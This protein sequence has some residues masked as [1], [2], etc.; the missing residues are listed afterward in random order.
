MA[1]MPNSAAI[2]NEA[3]VSLKT[4]T[5]NETRCGEQ[6]TSRPTTIAANSGRV[7]AAATKIAAT[8]AIPKKMLMICIRW[9]TSAGPERWFIIAAISKGIPGGR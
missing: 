5:A 8:V 6:A 2:M 1:D 4:Y 7:A 9:T 3:G